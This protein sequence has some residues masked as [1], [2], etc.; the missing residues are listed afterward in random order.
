MTKYMY[1]SSSASRMLKIGGSRW[2]YFMASKA[3]AYS[4]V[5]PNTFVP[6][7]MLKKWQSLSMKHAMNRP[8]AVKWSIWRYTSF[9]MLRA[10]DSST[11][12]TWV[13]FTSMPLYVVINSRNFPI[14]TLNTHL[15]ELSFMSCLRINLNASS[16][17]ESARSSFYF[18]WQCHQ[19]RLPV[20]D[21]LKA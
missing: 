16:S 8:K 21:L 5:Q 14:L 18:W 15:S 11:A 19:Y 7:I 17:D 20:W 3:S 12:L 2:Y 1:N 13:G 9:L 4:L 6:H 10:R